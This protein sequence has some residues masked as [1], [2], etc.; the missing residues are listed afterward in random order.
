M[1]QTFDTHEQERT[2]EDLSAA[3]DQLKREIER[4]EQAEEALQKASTV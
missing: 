3:N 2:K 4:R 1:T